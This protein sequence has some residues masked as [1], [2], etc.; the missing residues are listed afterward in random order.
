MKLK[1]AIQIIQDRERR[2]RNA[3]KQIKKVDSFFGRSDNSNGKQ[4]G[5]LTG[6]NEMRDLV[7]VQSIFPHSDV[8][9][10]KEK[11]GETTIRNAISKAVHHY[12]MCHDDED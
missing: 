9:A 6:T 3:Q 1:D 4:N 5:N 11:A 8:L 12:L 2:M 7:H 10:L